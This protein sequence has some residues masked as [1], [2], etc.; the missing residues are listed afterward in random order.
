M[1]EYYTE[2][3]QRSHFFNSL[4]QQ[5]FYNLGIII[6]T[7]SHLAITGIIMKKIIKW[8]NFALF[9]LFVTFVFFILYLNRGT[10][11]Q[12]DFLFDETELVMPAFISLIFLAGAL[13]GIVVTLILSI[14]NFGDS[15]RQKRELKAAQKSLKKLQEDTAL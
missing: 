3:S 1:E 9:L 15:W 7:L 5:I 4:L 2:D 14:S 10:T 8:I 13:C 6:F 11:V 12:F